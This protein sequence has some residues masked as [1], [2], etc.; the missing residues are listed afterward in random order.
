MNDRIYP[1]MVIRSQTEAIELLKKEN[2]E[3]QEKN[4]MIN[5]AIDDTYSSSQDIISECKAEIKEANDNATW[6]HNRY[7]AVK[8]ENQQLHNKID[9]AMNLVNNE[10]YKNRCN[11]SSC[12][13]YYLKEMK[14]IL[15]D[16][17]ID[18]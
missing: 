8:K 16:S 15:K 11:C 7:N 4:R 9:K 18:D 17:D 13:S 10:I 6:W 3:L 5:Q 1:S 14:E 12:N 2:K